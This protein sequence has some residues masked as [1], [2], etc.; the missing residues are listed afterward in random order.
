MSCVTNIH[1][2]VLGVLTHSTNSVIK[3]SLP[4]FNKP[5]ILFTPSRFSYVRPIFEP[6]L[7]HW[8]DGKLRLRIPS[9]NS[10]YTHV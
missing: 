6:V 10:N 3:V 4:S 5:G 7:R 9:L 8:Q 1:T 2:S